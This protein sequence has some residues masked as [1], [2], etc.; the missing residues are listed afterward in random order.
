MHS[1]TSCTHSHTVHASPTPPTAPMAPISHPLTLQPQNIAPP[2][3]YIK[4]TLSF[5]LSFLLMKLKQS[6]TSKFSTIP[7]SPIMSLFNQFCTRSVVLLIRPKAE[8]HLIKVVTMRKLPILAV[9]MTQ[10]WL[11]IVQHLARW[12]PF[13]FHFCNLYVSENICT[14]F[15]K[16]LSDLSITPALPSAIL[17]GFSS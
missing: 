1:L 14:K 4:P 17:T 16:N 8:C 12:P 3:L 15:E 5:L 9:K 13:L 10:I 11:G 7:V 2:G 6:E